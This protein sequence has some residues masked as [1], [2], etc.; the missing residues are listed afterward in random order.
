MPKQLCLCAAMLASTMLCAPIFAAESPGQAREGLYVVDGQ[1]FI[2]RAAWF[3]IN[4]WLSR[5]PQKTRGFFM[6]IPEERVG[7][8]TDF[9]SDAGFNVAFFTGTLIATPDGYDFTMLDECIERARKAHL[10]ITLNFDLGPPLWIIEREGWTQVTDEGKEIPILHGRIHHNAEEFTRV[11]REYW[12]PIIDHIRDNPVVTDYQLS[13]ET[14]AYNQYAT[15]QSR[16]ISYDDWTLEHFREYMKARYT[17]AEISERFGNSPEFYASWDDVFPPRGPDSQW[18]N[19][20]TEGSDFSGRGLPKYALARWDWYKFKKQVAADCYVSEIELLRELD[21]RNRPIFYEYNH[22]P[23]MDTRLFPLDEAVGR[24]EGFCVCNGEFAG[25]LSDAVQDAAYVKACGI[26]PWINNELNAGSGDTH[27]GPNTDAAAIRRHIWLNIGLGMQGYQFWAFPNLVGAATEFTVQPF[28]PVSPINLPMKYFETRHCNRMIDSRTTSPQLDVG[29]LYLDDST[30]NWTYVGTFKV[31]G[32]GIVDALSACG[33]ASRTGI[34]SQY[35]LDNEAI[36]HYK[37]LFLPRTPRILEGHMAKLAAYVRNGGTLV[38][39][40]RTG[41]TGE[42]MDAFDTYPGGILADVSGIQATEMTSGECADAPYE[43]TIQGSIVHM[44]VQTHI[45]VPTGSDAR[46][47]SKAD[48]DPIITVNHYGKGKC[49]Y[50]AGQIFM[51][52]PADATGVFVEKLLSDSGLKP[53]AAVTG[54][55]AADTG[56]FV[57]RRTGKTGDL[58]FLIENENRAHDLGITLDPASLD[59]DRRSAYQVFECFSDESHSVSAKEDWSFSTTLEPIGVRVYLVTSEESLDNILPSAQRMNIPREPGKVLAEKGPKGPFR[60]R[61]IPYRTDDALKERLA[62]LRSRRL[63]AEQASPA[64]PVDLG[65]GYA[66]VD[67]SGYC[68]S[69]VTEMVRD[70]NLTPRNFGAAVDGDVDPDSVLPIGNGKVRLGDVPAMTLD[71]FVNCYS[72]LTGLRV[73]GRVRTLHF[74]HGGQFSEHTTV[75]G[76]YRVNYADGSHEKVPMVL[77]TTMCDFSRASFWPSKCE[78]IWTG[79]TRDGG[80]RWLWRFDWTNP[81]PDKS[82]ATIDVVRNSEIGSEPV[83]IWAITLKGGSAHGEDLAGSGG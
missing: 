30:F 48:G 57:T 61:Q 19:T 12:T 50:L 36:D 41:Q 44:D 3:G 43:V 53:A 34:I 59:L 25:A 72:D 16:E 17:L 9:Y 14:H 68:T 29:I 67:L 82:I 56:V 33:F 23:Y 11:L 73:E 70:I 1:P 81:H 80:A 37:V 78:R 32:K 40:G 62:A 58:V 49:Y 69:P 64:A 24:T 46:V 22:G 21:D 13:G 75:L 15:F 42:L 28:D 63:T 65:G 60:A 45:I 52:T 27:T 4:T 71:R 8:E 10:K 74:F 31:D 47:L 55:G 77:G 79:K 18:D 2:K 83:S 39:M 54:N 26:G 76:Y 38:L 35:Q 6:T 66:A 51:T 7:S 20:A 5:D